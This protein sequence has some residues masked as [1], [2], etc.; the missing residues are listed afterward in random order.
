[1]ITIP[2]F[3]SPNVRAWPGHEEGAKA[4]YLSIEDTLTHSFTTDAHFSAYSVPA[5]E[6]RLDSNALTRPEL[7][8]GL[9]MVLLVVDIDDSQAHQDKTPARADW[10]EQEKAKVEKLFAQHPGGFCYDSR[11]GYRLIYRTDFLLKGEEAP[12]QWRRFYYSALCYLYKNF[13][14]EGDPSCSDWTRLYR[15]PHATREDNDT[16]EFRATLGDVKTLAH[17]ELPALSDKEALEIAYELSDPEEPKN[18]WNR[19]VNFFKP[20][21]AKTT[22][23]KGASANKNREE[24]AESKTSKTFVRPHR[25]WGLAALQEETEL[26]KK[27]TAGARTP[28]LFNAS[29]RLFSIAKAGPLDREEVEEKLREACQCNGW[30]SEYQDFERQTGN[31]WRLSNARDLPTLKTSEGPQ[32]AT[33]LRGKKGAPMGGIVNVVRIAK[34]DS[35]YAGAWAL[36]TFSSHILLQRPI[37]GSRTKPGKQ[38]DKDDLT[39]FRTYCSEVYNLIPSKDDTREA[40]Y[41]AAKEC[42]YSAA[43]RWIESL[44]SWDGVPRLDSWLSMYLYAE[45]S[46]YTRLIGAWWLLQSVARVYHPGEQTDGTLI[47]EGLEQGEG[48]SSLAFA[49]VPDSTWACDQPLDSARAKE[50]AEILQGKLIV[51]LA[52]LS[53]FRRADIETIKAFLTQRSDDYRPPWGEHAYPHPRQC[54]FLG[55]TNNERYLKENSSN[56]RFW[57]VR[58]EFL[59]REALIRDRDQLW[60]EARYRYL[61]G[62]KWWPQTEEQKRLLRAVTHERRVVDESFVETIEMY[63]R[64]PQE[65]RTRV[66]ATEVLTEALQVQPSKFEQKLFDN[67]SKTLKDLGWVRSE[68]QSRYKG[69]ITRLYNAPAGWE[70]FRE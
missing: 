68:K 18:L 55:T 26:L 62:E 52:E 69:K 38:L 4:R 19:I 42:S 48:K 8:E 45:D 35:N 16:P 36:D 59:D 32:S 47:L 22:Q 29:L 33:L 34:Q 66:C 40:I 9:P 70:Y 28:A 58:V 43:L 21:P 61:Q 7:I 41:A 2:V 14:I 10:R 30:S 57:P 31:A 11:G 24:T 5:I 49:L 65:K 12:K 56:R 54:I 50:T 25:G 53:A 13:G 1:M 17:L 37:A 46:Q 63:L 44:P 60:A 15:C 51:E 6:R 39:N 67:V 20:K 3:A 27:A 64:N 23:E